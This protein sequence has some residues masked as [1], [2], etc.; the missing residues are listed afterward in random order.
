MIESL[1]RGV[2]FVKNSDTSSL[3][4]SPKMSQDVRF[5]ARIMK[6]R[7]ALKIVLKAASTV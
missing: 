4:A 6:Q 7:I 1:L 3:S 2:Q 5:V